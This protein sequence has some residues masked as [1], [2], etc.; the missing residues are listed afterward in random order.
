MIIEF[1]KQDKK[2]E[3]LHRVSRTLRRRFGADSDEYLVQY[4]FVVALVI[5]TCDVRI[6]EGC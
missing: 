5:A 6:S 1:P 2:Q 3:R 4:L